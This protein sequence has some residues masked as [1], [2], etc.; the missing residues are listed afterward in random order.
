[1]GT[2]STIIQR[3]QQTNQKAWYLAF[4]RVA[5]SL[6][7]LKELLFRWPEFDLLYS[8]NSFLKF[9]PGGLYF[10]H[11]YLPVLKQHY[12]LVIYLCLVLLILN[13]T[14]I[15]RNLVAI[16][17][18]LALAVLKT[19]N[20][21]FINGGDLAAL[22]LTF[23]LAAA[24]SYSY[25]TIFKYKPLS[26]RK[27]KLYNQ[28]SNLAAY[29]IMINLS[30]IYFMAAVGKLEDTQW[31]SGMALNY[32]L[33]NEHYFIF[34]NSSRHIVVPTPLLFILDYGVIV[35]E[36]AAP[37]LIWYKRFRLGTFVLLFLMHLVIYSFFMLY[38]MSEVFIL[39]YGLF[40]SEQEIRSAWKKISNLFQKKVDLPVVV[41]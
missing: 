18:F 36:L 3:L 35:L 28:L 13:I 12:M 31:R 34:A 19:M 25:F 1:M 26:E 39:Q 38:G 4:L 33:N 30:F 20:N 6:W 17:L 21:T 16:L 41:K 23:Y 40:F 11:P 22:L 24:N 9:T 14:G 8:N 37:F 27:E 29:G 5:I 7:L 2:T 32:Y 10:L 15:G